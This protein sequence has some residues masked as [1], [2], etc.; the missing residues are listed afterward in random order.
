V[1]VCVCVQSVSVESRVG[2]ECVEL[3]R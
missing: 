2:G 1:V 3:C